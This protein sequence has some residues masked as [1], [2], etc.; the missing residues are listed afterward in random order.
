MPKLLSNIKGIVFLLARPVYCHFMCLYIDSKIP[1]S[2]NNVDCSHFCFIVGL[3]DRRLQRHCGCPHGM[4]INVTDQRSCVPTSEEPY[5]NCP[6]GSFQCHSGR[7]VAAEFRCDKENDCDDGSDERKCIGPLSYFSFQFSPRDAVQA[8]PIAVMR[9]LSIRPSI[10][11]SV[12][13][14]NSVKTNKRIF[15]IF[16]HWVAKPF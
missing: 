8:R 12:T 11:V 13:F 9:C 5:P 16:H 6:T 14:V 15:K 1:C 3:E 10:R 2:G 7:C 4:T